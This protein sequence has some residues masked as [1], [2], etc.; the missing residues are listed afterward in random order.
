MTIITKK[1]GTF[2]Y[3]HSTYLLPKKSKLLVLLQATKNLTKNME[4]TIDET[5]K[6]QRDRGH[7]ATESNEKQKKALS[8]GL[9]CYY[10]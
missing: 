10:Y 3:S 6:V 4:I 5:F 1:I 8:L 9:L 7:S 2:T